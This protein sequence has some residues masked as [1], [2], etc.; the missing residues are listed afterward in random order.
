MDY[1]INWIE[2]HHSH[3]ILDSGKIPLSATWVPEVR[4]NRRN[5]KHQNVQSLNQ[6]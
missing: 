4:N 3:K 2:K 5:L 1:E 6:L